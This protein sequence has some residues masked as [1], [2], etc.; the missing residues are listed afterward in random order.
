[1]K[2]RVLIDAVC[3]ALSIAMIVIVVTMWPSQWPLILI[4]GLII[5]CVSASDLEDELQKKCSGTKSEE[6]TDEKT[7]PT[8][9]P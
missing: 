5:L 1:M 8:D 2:K 4:E 3:V 6:P 7:S 9:Q